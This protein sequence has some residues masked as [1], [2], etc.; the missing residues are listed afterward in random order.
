[1]DFLATELRDKPIIGMIGGVGAWF[2]QQLSESHATGFFSDSNF[3]WGI[4]SKVGI[5]IGSMI[6]VITLILKMK[7]L[8]NSFKKK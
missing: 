6:A 2:I 3:V 1:M 7:E 4:M 8:I 5:L